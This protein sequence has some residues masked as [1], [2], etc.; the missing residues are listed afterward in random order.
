MSIYNDIVWREKGKRETCVAN[1]V[2]VA[3]C[4][5]KFA[6]GHWSFLG[7]GSENKWYG[8]H[9]YKPNGKWVDVA[10]I[11]MINFSES[12]HPAFRGSSAFERR[13]LKSNGKG[14][15]TTTDI[16]FNVVF[17]VYSVP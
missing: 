12:G 16:K 3:D 11:L 5:R 4:A 10:D 13:D 9:V 2:I 6:E 14:G 1:S 17:C 15:K 7:P 8:T